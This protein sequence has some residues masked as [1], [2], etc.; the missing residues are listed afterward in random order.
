MRQCYHISFII[1]RYF[2]RLFIFFEKILFVMK[3]TIF[4]T[5]KTIRICLRIW[6]NNP[7]NQV[8]SGGF[9]FFLQY[10][11]KLFLCFWPKLAI[12]Y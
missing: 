7:S 1:A 9:Y 8:Q 11:C 5:K 6:L 4:V 3:K 12:I 10:N 2:Y